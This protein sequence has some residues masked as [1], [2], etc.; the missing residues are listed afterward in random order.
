[1][2][3]VW[4]PTELE[5]QITFMEEHGYAFSYTKYGLINEVSVDRRVIISG[6]GHITTNDMQKCCWPGYLTV[7][8]DRE[9]VG[10]QQVMNLREHNDYAL[11]LNVSKEADCYLLD[12]KLAK[13]RTRW[14]LMGRY[15]MTD[16]VKWRYECYRIEEGMNPWEAAWNTMRN[17]CYGIWKWMR[18]V[19]RE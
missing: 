11:W 9:K 8:Y 12:E 6:K 3:D 13:M 14:G 7:M 16:K 19:K 10:L 4:E 17:G 18:Y 5:R 15:L 2:G 1:V